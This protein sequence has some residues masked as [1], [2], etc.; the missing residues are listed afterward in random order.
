MYQTARPTWVDASSSGPQ[1]NE[2]K[3]PNRAG[4]I[5]AVAL[6]IVSGL[7]AKGLRTELGWVGDILGLREVRCILYR[8]FS[9][10]S[11]AVEHLTSGL[12][13]MLY[14]HVTLR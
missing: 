7:A 12:R 13:G 3:Q 9:L 11:V 5:V 1:R 10:I 14:R 8:S 2:L 4:S 6:S